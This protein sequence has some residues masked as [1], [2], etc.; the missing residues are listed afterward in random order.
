MRPEETGVRPGTAHS[1]EDGGVGG[2]VADAA[3][4]ADGATRGVGGSG[5]VV[6]HDNGGVEVAAAD[7]PSDVFCGPRT[8]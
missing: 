6:A 3:L 2:G 5:A 1:D 7:T 8:Q 4:Q